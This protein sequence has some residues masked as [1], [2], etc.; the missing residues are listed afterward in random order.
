MSDVAEVP[1]SSLVWVDYIPVL[2]V[3]PKTS[4][5]R[6]LVLFLSGLSG[7]KESTLPFLYDLAAAEWAA[8]KAGHRVA[9]RAR[10]ACL[11]PLPASCVARRAAGERSGCDELGRGAQRRPAV[12]A[13]TDGRYAWRAG[14]GRVDPWDGPDERRSGPLVARVPDVADGVALCGGKGKAVRSATCTERRLR[15]RSLPS[16][17]RRAGRGGGGFGFSR[18]R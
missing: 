17:A 16:P 1:S 8:R 3:E 18:R 15:L 6:R 5:A 9:G 10:G 12:P 7:T 13:G 4:G 2:W 11:R 14:A